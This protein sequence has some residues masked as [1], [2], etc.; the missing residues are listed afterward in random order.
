[1]LSPTE[2]WSKRQLWPPV[3]DVYPSALSPTQTAFPGDILWIIYRVIK[4]FLPVAGAASFGVF[5]S[6]M[7]GKPE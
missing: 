6:A 7:A 1:V 4:S 3:I 5:Q 2:E